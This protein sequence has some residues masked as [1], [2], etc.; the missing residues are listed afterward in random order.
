M[1]LSDGWSRQVSAAVRSFHAA[2]TTSTQSA[3]PIRLPWTAIFSM[4]TNGS[5]KP[6]EPPACWKGEMLFPGLASGWVNAAAGKAQTSF[7]I[8][9]QEHQQ[10]T[11]L[12]FKFANLSR[13]DPLQAGE[14]RIT[15]KLVDYQLVIEARFCRRENSRSA[16]WLPFRKERARALGKRFLLKKFL[17]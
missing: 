3:I 8:Y 15:S 10:S 1:R 9:K 11:W 12:G 7:P 6:F 17:T 13:R 4:S 14:R 5:A 2:T 16:D